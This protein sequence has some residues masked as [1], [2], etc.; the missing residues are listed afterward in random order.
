M[1]QVIGV[2]TEKS[3]ENTSSLPESVVIGFSVFKIHHF[4]PLM[5]R[6]ISNPTRQ[7]AARAR[8][9]LGILKIDP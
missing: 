2:T 9:V 5:A 3:R 1:F 4:C 7:Q 8:I 6:S